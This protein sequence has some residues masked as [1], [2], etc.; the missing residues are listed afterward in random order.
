MS[1]LQSINRS[2]EQ[3]RRI[4]GGRKA[5]Q[6]AAPVTSNK[7]IPF[8]T[9][10]AMAQRVL[11]QLKGKRLDE[12]EYNQIALELRGVS[13]GLTT[14]QIIASNHGVTRPTIYN[15][16]RKEGIRLSAPRRLATM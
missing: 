12:H 7:V 10:S 2:L 5:T 9:R 16:A 1:T 14:V 11:N 8:H 6:N 15:I 3:T 4:L 13:S